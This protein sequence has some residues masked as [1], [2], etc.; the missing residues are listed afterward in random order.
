M[1]GLLWKATPAVNFFAN[2][3]RGFETPTFTEMSYKP[4]NTPG[5]NF[6]LKPSKSRN[7][8]AGVKAFV[9]PESKLEATLFD[10][11]T[12]DEIVVASSSGGRTSYMNAGRTGR[13]GLELSFDSDLGHGFG[14][15]AAY[16]R[17]KAIYRD[18]FPTTTAG[19]NVLAGNTIAGMPTTMLHGEVSWKH[20]PSGFS[21]AL[22]FHHVGQ[23]FANDINSEAADGYDI[24]SLRL[25]LA[26]QDGKW[27]L[28]EF[29][30]CDNL[31]D[32]KYAGSVI[33]NQAA[34]QFYEAAPGRN[35][36]VGANASYRF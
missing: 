26:Q 24:A 30:R 17:M 13:T 18:A 10:V 36:T 33:V 25:G 5:L 1:V 29:V 21:T 2:V 7:M 9:S 31:T 3:G 23:M 11:E 4:D 19:V 15:F 35:W 27:K 8:E 16:T 22:E 20:V 12:F 14:L 28:K 6:A 32:R 34:S